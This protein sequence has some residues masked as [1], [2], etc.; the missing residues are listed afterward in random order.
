MLL[1]TPMTN[2]E[3]ITYLRDR[4]DSLLNGELKKLVF[5]CEVEA[6]KTKKV[7]KVCTLA[8]YATST[9]LEIDGQ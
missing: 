9:R 2:Q 6:K 8:E 1:L 5:G 3:K 7:Y 4:I